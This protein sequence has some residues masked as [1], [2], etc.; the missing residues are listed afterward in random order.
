MAFD[1]EREITSL[2]RAFHGTQDDGRR[3]FY[4]CGVRPPC[5]C[6][7]TKPIPWKSL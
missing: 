7:A 4:L 5:N 3:F 1:A 6:W 2:W